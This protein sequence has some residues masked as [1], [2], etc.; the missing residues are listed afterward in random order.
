MDDI[1]AMFSHLLGEMDNLSQSLTETTTKPPLQRQSTF[2]FTDLNESLHELE[3][4]DLDALVAD[5][6]ADSTT[7]EFPADPQT[8]TQSESKTEGSSTTQT[9][10]P[11]AASPPSSNSAGSPAGLQTSEPQTKADKIK[12][13][14]ENLTEAKLIVK[15]LMSDHSYKVVMVD[16]KQTIREVLDMLFEKTYCDCSVDWSL[17]ETSPELQTERGFEDHECFAESLSTWTSES[18]NKIYFVSRPQKYVMFKDPQLFYMWKKKAASLT[19]I[20]EQA[21]QLLLKVSTS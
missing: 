12:L 7:S 20:N 11:R 15:V 1:D 6:R 9:S 4:Q 2:G 16:K 18:Q 21:K 19:G 3:D 13:A 5:L 14:L 17:C 8:C 10:E